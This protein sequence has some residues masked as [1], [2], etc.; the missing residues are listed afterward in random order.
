MSKIMERAVQMQ[1]LAFITENGVLSAYQSGFR[2]KY[3]TE[4][5]I[6]H[7][8]DSILEKMDNRLMTGAVFIDL[9]KAFDLVDHKYTYYTS[10]KI[11]ALGEAVLTGFE[12]T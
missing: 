3:S 1:L 4:T 5:A 9:K 7:L 12:I 8:V 6:V 11:T 10:W 2:K